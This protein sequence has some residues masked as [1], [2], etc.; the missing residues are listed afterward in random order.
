M[1]VERS[2][3]RA[4]PLQ[5]DETIFAIGDVHGCHRQLALLLEEFSALTAEVPATLVFSAI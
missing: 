3:W 5:L 4:A 2:E 1:P